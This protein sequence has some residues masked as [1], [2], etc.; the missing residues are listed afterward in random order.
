MKTKASI[1]KLSAFHVFIQ[2]FWAIS[3]N[4][5]KNTWMK[6]LKFKVIQLCIEP[7]RERKKTL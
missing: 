7:L 1:L 4:A 6:T 2:N 3:Q 5:Y